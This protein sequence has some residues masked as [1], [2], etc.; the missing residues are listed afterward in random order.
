M[1]C[2]IINNLI[3]VPAALRNCLLAIW[4]ELQNGAREQ[5]LGVVTKECD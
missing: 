4:V 2:L 5:E 1:K 3:G